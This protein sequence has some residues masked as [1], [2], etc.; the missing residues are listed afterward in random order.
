MCQTFSRLEAVSSSQCSGLGSLV[1]S[2]TVHYSKTTI[3]TTLIKAKKL[4]KCLG[5]ATTL[6]LLYFEIKFVLMPFAV[7]M[8]HPLHKA[9]DLSIQPSPNLVKQ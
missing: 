4:I 8:Q 5:C 3:D 6:V 9:I 1:S 7:P 2:I